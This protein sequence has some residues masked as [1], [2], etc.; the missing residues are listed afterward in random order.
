MKSLIVVVSV[1]HGNTKLIAQVM[2]E[3]LKAEIR[4]PEEVNLSELGNFDLLGFGSGIYF[5]HFH[6]RLV[7]FVKSLSTS[8]GRP[9]FV[10]STSG[11]GKEEYNRSLERILAIRGY[12]LVGSFACR[13]YD[14]FGPF[15]F[16]GG[17]NRGKPGREELERA[18]SFARTILGLFRVE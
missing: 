1:H 7:H 6:R 11:L 5:G 18:K 3:V 16:F 17:L 14:T 15:K 2:G 8:L 4:E 13:G 10:F 12:K 9:A